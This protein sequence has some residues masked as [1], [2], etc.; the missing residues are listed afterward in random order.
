MSSVTLAFMRYLSP[1]ASVDHTQR[2]NLL[3]G[4][5]KTSRPVEKLIK[6]AGIAGGVLALSQDQIVA[7]MWKSLAHRTI[8]RQQHGDVNGRGRAWRAG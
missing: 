3:G 7:I 2:R 4:K 8:S 1:V 6:T 5:A